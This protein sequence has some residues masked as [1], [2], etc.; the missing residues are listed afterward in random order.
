[1]V[2]GQAREETYALQP[3]ALCLPGVLC[4]GLGGQRAF[5]G[6]RLPELGASIRY[7][8]MKVALLEHA[9]GESAREKIRIHPLRLSQPPSRQSESFR[10]A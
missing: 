6:N 8:L 2:K 3:P 1:M 4:S 7:K 5:P 10:E 9:G